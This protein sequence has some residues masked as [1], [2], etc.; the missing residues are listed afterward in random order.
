MGTDIE[1][2]FGNGDVPAVFNRNLYSP[3]VNV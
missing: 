3:A 2:W 1:P